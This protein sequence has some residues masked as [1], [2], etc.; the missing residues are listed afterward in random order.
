MRINYTPERARTHD[1]RKLI[2]LIILIILL[3]LTW[4][5][6]QSTPGATPPP[7]AL[8]AANTAEAA[9]SAAPTVP[10][11]TQA[12]PTEAP[13]TEAPIAPALTSP[14]GGESVSGNEDVTLSGTGAP[15]SQ[16]Q[17][18]I[19]GQPVG[20][21][22]VGPDGTWSFPIKLDPGEHSLVVQTLDA[23]GKVVAESEAVKVTAEAPAVPAVKPA[24]TSPKPG[25][26]LNSGDVTLN[27]TGAPGI[28][29][30][31]VVDGK[32]V[33]TADVGADGTWSFPVK[34]DPGDH[35]ITVQGLDVGGNVSAESDAVS[36][37]AAAPAPTPTPTPTPN[38]QPA[39]G[40]ACVG[41]RG[42]AE[43]NVWIVGG[44]DTMTYIG[45]E[46]G[47]PLGALIAANPQVK[48]PDLIFP[49]QQINLPR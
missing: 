15:G 6:C 25:D 32:V 5:F 35:T 28:K 11:S 9:T 37:S 21:T 33:G 16:V 34:L 42:R 38:P 27:G 36:V 4:F 17:I 20:P 43:G 8:A 12:P 14:K 41:P 24:L 23:G 13:P 48:N 1:I 10:L 30:Q 26:I 46:T 49:D 31:I 19:D 40:D 39:G 22:T 3:L 2:I 7:T 47:I 29:V 18:V 45:K 44:C